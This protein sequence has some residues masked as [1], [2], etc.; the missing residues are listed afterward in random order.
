MPCA[1]GGSASGFPGS[2]FPVRPAVEKYMNIGI[3]IEDD[4]LVTESGREN[5]SKKAPRDVAEIEA[6]MAEKSYLNQ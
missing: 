1:K 5:L 6:L 2:S 3:R 4:V